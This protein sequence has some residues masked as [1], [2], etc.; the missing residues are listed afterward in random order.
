VLLG[1]FIAFMIKARHT[2]AKVT[3]RIYQGFGL[4]GLTYA[5]TRCFF[6]ASDYE[7]AT[8]APNNTYLLFDEVTAAY[9][10]TF[11]ALIFIYYAVERLMLN[12]KPVF[13]AIAII[14]A[15]VCLLA[16]V[17]TSL[18]IG[19]DLTGKGSGP[20]TIAQ[21]TLYITGPILIIGIVA[22][23]IKIAVNSSGSVRKR[24]ITALI[25]LLVLSA[26]LLLDMDILS[27]PSFD[28]IRLLLSPFCFIA[29][30]LTFFFAQK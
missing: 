26:G 6:L 16:F 8:H 22:L 20:Q 29:G 28:P 24:S 13:M 14:A 7:N 12:R 18:Q 27:N 2:E 15:G 9:T 1:G 10:V 19:V 21:Y 23:Y 4:F 17:L 11:A 25:G 30:T 3:K 5:I